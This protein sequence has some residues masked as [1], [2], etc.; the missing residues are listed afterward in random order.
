MIRNCTDCDK[1]A[2]I[3]Y[4]TNGT[5]GNARRKVSREQSRNSA[6]VTNMPQLDITIPVQC[7]RGLCPVVELLYRT[8]KHTLTVMTSRQHGEASAPLQKSWRKNWAPIFQ[9]PRELP[10]ARRAVNLFANLPSPSP[11]C[12]GCCDILLWVCNKPFVRRVVSVLFAMNILQ[13]SCCPRFWLSG[14]T[15]PGGT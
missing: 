9:T 3:R 11:P 4:C 10:A 7:W 8:Q 1:I 15:A 12:W 2:T 6:R 14:P 5:T 13:I